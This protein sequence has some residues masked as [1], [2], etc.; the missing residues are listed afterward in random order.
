VIASHGPE[1]D[2]CL[3][4]L[5]ESRG[6]HGL[7]VG[8]SYI[9]RMLTEGVPTVLVDSSSTPHMP[10][11]VLL[12]PLSLVLVRTSAQAQMLVTAGESVLT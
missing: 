7:L 8:E 10:V 2:L 12:L 3:R 4:F 11:L 6:K 5:D 9:A 1:R